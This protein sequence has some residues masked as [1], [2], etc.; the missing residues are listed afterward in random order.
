MSSVLAFHSEDVILFLEL[1]LKIIAKNVASFLENYA[2]VEIN[3]LVVNFSQYFVLDILIFPFLPKKKMTLQQDNL[4]NI[5]ER[6]A[7]SV[8]KYFFCK[9]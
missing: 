6:P 9:I 7:L 5:C 1:L 8:A 4:Q 3:K 2:P